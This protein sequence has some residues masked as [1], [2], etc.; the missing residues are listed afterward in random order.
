MLTNLQLKKLPNGDILTIKVVAHDSYF[1]KLFIHISRQYIG[2]CCKLSL[3]DKLIFMFLNLPEKYD[4][5]IYFERQKP[6][7]TRN[8]ESEQMEESNEN[9]LDKIDEY[10]IG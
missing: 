1:A 10:I 8:R 7:M 9:P 3:R 2:Q 6:K 4:E 5:F